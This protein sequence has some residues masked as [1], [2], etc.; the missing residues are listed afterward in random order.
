MPFL[1]AF[2]LHAP[3]L[4]ALSIAAI[5]IVGLVLVIHDGWVAIVRALTPKPEPKKKHTYVHKGDTYTVDGVEWVFDGAE[6]VH[7]APPA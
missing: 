6:W 3:F 4:F 1:Y 7:R 2:Y 5:I